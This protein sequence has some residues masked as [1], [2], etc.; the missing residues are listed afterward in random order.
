M[1][2]RQLPGWVDFFY[3]LTF[4][5]SFMTVYVVHCLAV[6]L[7]AVFH[8]TLAARGH[9]PVVAFAKVETMIDVSVEMIRP[10]IPRPRPDE[11]TAWE[12]LRAIVAI[13]RAAI[14]SALIVPVRTH[15]SYSN[16]DRNL[17]A[18]LMSR[19]R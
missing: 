8:G 14:R 6:K 3:L 7:R 19:D 13:W 10:V 1:D 15:G 4:A 2:R 16:T 9:R 11:N 18:C 5:G 17:R 12:P